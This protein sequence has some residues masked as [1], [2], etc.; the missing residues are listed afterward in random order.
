MREN[1]D[2][3]RVFFTLSSMLL[4][5]LY[6]WKLNKSSRPPLPSG[7]RGLPLVGNLLSLDQEL[8]TYFARLAQTYGPILKLQL[9][10]K[11]GIVVTSPSLAR[12]VLKDNDVVFANRDVPIAGLIGTY[13]GN[14]LVSAPYG[15][16]WRMLRKVC[17]LKMLSNT[18]LDSVYYLRRREVRQTVGYF[19][20][21]VGLPV[22]LGEQM[23]LTVLNVITSMLWGGTVEG[24]ERASLGA[25]FRQIVSEMTEILGKPNI[26]DLYPGLAR[27]D[28][29][30]V[31]KKMARLAQRF[32][33]MFDK[34]IGQRS[35]KVG[36]EEKHHIHQGGN[37]SRDFLQYLLELKDEADPRTPL[38]ITHVKALLMVMLSFNL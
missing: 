34:I 20:S 24:D 21:R 31:A 15:P 36:E 22:N 23:F 19:Y 13:G 37:E 16:E 9:G 11:I 25:E 35:L 38:T 29:Q 5:F 28:L 30:G 2:F 18:T 17:V 12:Q 8:H 1:D 26:S 33:K 27:F 6:V 32:D 7:P 4:I 10:K 3:T 14:D